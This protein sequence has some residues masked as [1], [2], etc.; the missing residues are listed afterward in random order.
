MMDDTSGDYINKENIYGIYKV[1]KRSKAF[2]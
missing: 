1:I 2:G